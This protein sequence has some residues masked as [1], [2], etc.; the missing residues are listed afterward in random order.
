MGT[1]KPWQNPLWLRELTCPGLEK[2]GRVND[3]TIASRRQQCFRRYRVDI[4]VQ[5]TDNTTNTNKPDPLLSRKVASTPKKPTTAHKSQLQGK[6]KHNPAVAPP[7]KITKRTSLA[8]SSS[9]L[10]SAPKRFPS[11]YSQD[12]LAGEEQPPSMQ[13]IASPDL[14]KCLW[15]HGYAESILVTWFGICVRHF[16]A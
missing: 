10:L 13:E 1:W 5:Y 6:P 9:H 15:P 16:P 3:R 11:M 14:A 12:L 4:V 2:V 8:S 7:R